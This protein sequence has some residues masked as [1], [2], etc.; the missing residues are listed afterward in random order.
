MVVERSSLEI[1]K[2]VLQLAT[3]WQKLIANDLTRRYFEYS[4]AVINQTGFNIIVAILC[5][6][7]CEARQIIRPGTL[8]ALQSQSNSYLQ[9]IQLWQS[10]YLR[11]G[12]NLTMFA[13][14]LPLVLSD[15][16]LQEMLYNLYNSSDAKLSVGIL[17][18]VYETVWVA[19]E[20]QPVYSQKKQF[21]WRKSGG[22]YYTPKPIVQYMVQST[23]DQTGLP[24]PQI[25]DPACGGGAFLI[26]AYQYL[27][28]HQL[29]CTGQF[30]HPF[31][32]SFAQ[33]QRVLNCLHGV[34]IDAQAV[35]IA[36]LSLWLKLYEGSSYHGANFFDISQIKIHCGNALSSLDRTENAPESLA[37]FDW[38]TFFSEAWRAGGFDIVLGN[39][40]YVD[41]ESMT[42]YLPDWRSYCTTHYQT[43]T[44]NWDLFCIFIEKALQLCR[45]GGITS[46]LV[47]NKLF[48]AQYAGA[49][50]SL[51]LQKTQL[52]SLRDYSRVP[53]FDAS[54]YPIVYLAQKYVPGSVNQTVTQS[55]NQITAAP[56]YEQMASIEQV[57]HSHTLDLH[58]WM[59]K[60][61]QPWS[62]GV[63]VQIKLMQRLDQLPKLRDVAQVSGAA[64]VAEAYEL[65]SQIQD[66]SSPTEADLQFVNSGTIDRYRILW[67]QKPVRY[68]GKVYRYPMIAA[69]NLVHLPPKRLI[70]AQQ[71]KIIVA[72]MSR[73][74]E[75]ALDERGRILAGKST[76]VILPKPMPAQGA[77]MTVDLRYLL[78]L[79]NSRLLS[80]YLQT[81]FSGNRLQGDYFRVG[82]PQ[83]RELPIALPDLKQPNQWQPY[84]QVIELVDTRHKL[85]CASLN[86][87]NLQTKLEFESGIID[88]EIDSLVNQIYQLSA[89]E[90]SA[91]DECEYL[92]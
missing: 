81:R 5:L 42:L 13:L 78:G 67:G 16:L 6:Y 32:L 47:P 40:P 39:P 29:D 57:A 14:P 90:I 61:T 2:S 88:T 28:E 10:C 79:L 17:G 65:Q 54:V 37:S 25:L 21:S 49:A 18:Q 68:L 77:T 23:I 31:Q 56:I 19:S 41:A 46:L 30:L 69:V 11:W 89:A 3:E 36:R 55:V 35:A 82:P 83:I 44:G 75:C 66:T 9:L 26:E 59:D 1:E 15:S 84:N 24:L 64:T 63:Q 73:R 53:I 91:L 74:L 80:F 85:D 52:I 4:P 58:S 50:R 7:L 22:I 86:Q 38:Q 43:A 33:R 48:S 72:G 76:V 87:V 62:I 27:L 34:D 92:R 70:Q 51:L 12:D 60:T 8:K 20:P 45:Y 71:S